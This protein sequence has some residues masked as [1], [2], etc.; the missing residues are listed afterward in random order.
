MSYTLPRCPFADP[1]RG[2]VIH[3][4]GVG[5]MQ[6]RSAGPKQIR[7]QNLVASLFGGRGSNFPREK[8]ASLA[9]STTREVHH[10]TGH[11]DVPEEHWK[12]ACV[13]APNDL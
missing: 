8:W 9:T 2:D 12:T 3:T 11:G 7:A 13:E 5:L 6:V 4:D 10:V 1:K